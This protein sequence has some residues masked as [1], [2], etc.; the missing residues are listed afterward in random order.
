[1]SDGLTTREQI[2]K[3]LVESLNLEDMTPEMIGD[4]MPLWGE[5]GLGLD[6][7][8]AL[9]LMVDLEQRYGIRIDDEDFEPESMATVARLEEFITGLM[10]SKGGVGSA[11]RE[12]TSA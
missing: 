11:A 4:E 7:V 5:D 12:D 9:E 8:D 3:I 1:M 2:K 10:A 6:S